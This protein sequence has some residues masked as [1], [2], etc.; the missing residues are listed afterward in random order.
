MGV[1]STRR[2]EAPK[3]HVRHGGVVGIGT[4]QVCPYLVVDLA[5]GEHE[6]TTA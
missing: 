2:L 4:M 5:A 3:L 6:G 1:P